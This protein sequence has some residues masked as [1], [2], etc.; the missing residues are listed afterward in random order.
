[1]DAL[2]YHYFLETPIWCVSP[3]GATNSKAAATSAAEG[4]MRSQRG[5]KMYVTYPLL[6][7]IYE[8]MADFI[9]QLND[10]KVMVNNYTLC[11]RRHGR[12]RI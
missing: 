5:E 3:G 12:L 10:G 1:M 4:L 11:K 9:F 7:C 2:G 6:S 8:M